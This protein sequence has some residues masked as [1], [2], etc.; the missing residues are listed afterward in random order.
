MFT[1]HDF[2]DVFT[3]TVP[4]DPN[5]EI[6]AAE[7]LADR[8]RNDAAFIDAF[9]CRECGD[10]T[11]G[12]GLAGEHVQLCDDC[13]VIWVVNH[14]DAAKVRELVADTYPDWFATTVSA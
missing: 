5:A 4:D 9:R 7:D 6:S 13:I 3:P 1:L 2:P 10:V 11:A 12:S 14:V 8:Q